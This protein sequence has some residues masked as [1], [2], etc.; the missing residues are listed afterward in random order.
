MYHPDC[1]GDTNPVK[2]DGVDPDIAIINRCGHQL[3]ILL[4]EED[5]SE[6]DIHRVDWDTINKKEIVDIIWWRP[7]D[8]EKL[9]LLQDTIVE[10]TGVQAL[11]R[12]GQFRSFGGGKMIPIGARTPAGGRKGDAYTS[13]AGLE[14][15][16]QRGLEML[17][18][19]AATS[20]ITVGAAKIVYPKLAID[21]RDLSIECDR[22]GMTGTNIYNCTGYMAPI[23]QDQDVTRGLCVQ[24]LLSADTAYKEYAFCNVEYQ[25]Y[26]TTT[27]NCLWSF[28]SDNLHGT[29]LPSTE[30]I[31]NLNSHAV[32]PTRMEAGSGTGHTSTMNTDEKRQSLHKERLGEEEMGHEEGSEEEGAEATGGTVWL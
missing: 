15:S 27:S 28:K 24:A 30:T 2:L 23:H 11:K 13:Y 5:I 20:A 32:D 22:I 31:K 7:F 8:D 9:A 12:G 18:N 10:S 3:K 26:S 17:F 21:L 16:T 4:E 29:M 19:Q 25:Y 1:V 14:A 6:D